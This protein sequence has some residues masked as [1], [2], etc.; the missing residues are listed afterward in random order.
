MMTDFRPL[1][2][3]D[4]LAH[5]VDLVLSGSQAD[6]P[7]VDDGDIVGLMTM[8]NVSEYMLIQNALREFRSSS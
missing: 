2:P 4:S 3:P 6:F 5:A 1:T 8:E 7:V